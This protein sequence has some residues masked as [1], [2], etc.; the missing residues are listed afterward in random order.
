M[1][2]NVIVHSRRRAVTTGYE[3]A[4]WFRKEL[5]HTGWH[6]HTSFT[7]LKPNQGGALPLPEEAGRSVLLT[8]AL[9]LAAAITAR[10]ILLI[11]HHQRQ[12][13]RTAQG[14]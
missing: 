11:L 1:G 7:D 2:N 8:T 6:L 9:Q 5:E 3:G 14:R 4:P 10:Q 12:M 13:E